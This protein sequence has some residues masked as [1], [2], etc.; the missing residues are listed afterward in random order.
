[1]RD[2]LL[3]PEFITEPRRITGLAGMFLAA[4]GSM[5]IEY[6]LTLYLQQVRGWSSLATAVSFL[7]FA[8]TMIVVN[9]FSAKVIDRLGVASVLTA[10]GLVSA[11]GL[12]LLA[13]ISSDSAY[14][15]I[16]LPGQ[17][18]LAVGISL[19]LSGSA[20]QS[21]ANVEEHQA[22]QAG[23][24]MNTAMELGPTVGLTVL[25]A[26]AATQADSV[27]G[28]ALAFG[29]AG[30]VLMLLAIVASMLLTRKSAGHVSKPGS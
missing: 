24:V 13:W 8:I 3:P 29:T 7:P 11:G 2:P 23:G 20:V 1:M 27:L 22:G 28:Y 6:V 16:L 18:L 30:V 26:V 21:T 12:G 25:M 15:A 17:I 4:A 14:S 5:L 9:Q 19:V 10:G